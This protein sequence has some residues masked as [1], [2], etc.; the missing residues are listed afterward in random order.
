MISDALKHEEWW[1]ELQDFRGQAANAAASRE[2]PQLLGL[3]VGRQGV[4]N[5]HQE[6]GSDRRPQSV[7]EVTEMPK[8]PDI[9]MLSKWG[10]N[11]GM[12]TH[13]LPDDVLHEPRLDDALC[14]ITEHS[15]SDGEYD[16]DPTEHV[17]Q[18]APD[19]GDPAKVPLLTG[20]RQP[21][22]EGPSAGGDTDDRRRHSRWAPRSLPRTGPSLRL[23]PR[24]GDK[25]GRLTGPSLS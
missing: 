13:H 8:R 4:Y 9:A 7:T 24:W 20:G 12:H 25:T 17:T 15:N 5:P 18:G 1:D 19:F 22:A 6:N 14:T 16:S 11:V 10:V 2:A 23:R 3:A 21:A